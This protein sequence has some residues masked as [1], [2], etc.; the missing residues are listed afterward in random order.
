MCVRHLGW[1]WL[2]LILVGLMT[3]AGSLASD[4]PSP[5]LASHQVWADPPS[6]KADPTTI[7]MEYVEGTRT[8]VL[9]QLD[10]FIWVKASNYRGIEIDGQTYY[11]LLSP[12]ASFD[13]LS[14][15]IVD[16][17]T[18]HVWKVIR[19]ADFTVVIYT[20]DDAPVRSPNFSARL[21]QELRAGSSQRPGSSQA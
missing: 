18:V 19:G 17:Q 12:H 7:I 21:T 5:A 15:G 6:A 9:L 2:T 4:P 1:A 11:Y 20:I 16:E 3:A 10:D 13:P 8:D 14:R